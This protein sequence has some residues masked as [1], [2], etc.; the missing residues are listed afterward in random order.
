M[1]S[2]PPYTDVPTERVTGENGI[3]YAYR[4]VGAGDDERVVAG[5]GGPH[6][7]LG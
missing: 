7:G 3:E 2:T 6:L 4:D 1:A 5:V